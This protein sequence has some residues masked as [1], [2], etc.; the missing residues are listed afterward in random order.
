M[1]DRLLDHYWLKLSAGNYCIH[2]IRVGSFQQNIIFIICCIVSINSSQTQNSLEATYIVVSFV[3]LDKKWKSSWMQ[4]CNVTRREICTSI[5]ISIFI[6]FLFIPIFLQLLQNIYF[7][8][9]QKMALLVEVPMLYSYQMWKWIPRYS[10]RIQCAT[11]YTAHSR[12]NSC[13]SK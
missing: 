2:N 10:N 8:T 3:G 5:N 9:A 12:Y 11:Y 6:S 13:H 4:L 1:N 7:N